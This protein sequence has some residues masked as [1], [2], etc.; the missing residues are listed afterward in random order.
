LSDPIDE[1]HFTIRCEID[2]QKDIIDGYL[3]DDGTVN[4]TCRAGDST[5]PFDFTNSRAFSIPL[6]DVTTPNQPPKTGDLI[7]ENPRRR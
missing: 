2:N 5:R 3:Q 6:S 1:S 4:L 7:D